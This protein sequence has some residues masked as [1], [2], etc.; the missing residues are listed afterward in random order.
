MTNKKKKI[1]KKKSKKKKPSKV[2]GENYLIKIVPN[3]LATRIHNWENLEGTWTLKENPLDKDNKL[4][5]EA[6]DL[7]IHLMS[8]FI[9]ELKKNLLES[10]EYV[11]D[12]EDNPIGEKILITYNSEDF[13]ELSHEFSEL[14]NTFKSNNWE[15]LNVYILIKTK[16]LGDELNKIFF[17]MSDYGFYASYQNYQGEIIT[18]GYDEG[19]YDTG[20]F[21]ANRGDDQKE[22]ISDKNNPMSLSL[23]KYNEVIKTLSE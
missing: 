14:G 8:C 9:Y 4:N 17:N 22:Y 20:Y 3:F 1:K 6:T 7:C 16:I 5:Q 15:D 10:D 18:Q 12:G 2:K 11:S 21:A 23:K 19:E 13:H